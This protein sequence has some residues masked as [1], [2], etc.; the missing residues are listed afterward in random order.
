[1]EPMLAGQNC[2]L[3]SQVHL[4]YADRALHLCAIAHHLPVQLLLLQ[5]LD[6]RLGCRWRGIRLRVGFH[7]LGDDPVKA[8]LS[9]HSVTVGGIWA[10][11]AE[12]EGKDVTKT[13][14]KTGVLRPRRL[15]STATHEV[16]E[17]S[18]RMIS[19][20]LHKVTSGNS[21]GTGRWS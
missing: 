21:G 17:C 18:G 13:T 11:W 10:S 2:H 1:M 6:G 15:G 16:A 12:E 3:V 20:G 19:T 9:V 14:N 5:F 8:L 4:I 7:E